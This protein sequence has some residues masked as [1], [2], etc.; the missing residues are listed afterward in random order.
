MNCFIPR[1]D[2]LGSDVATNLGVGLDNRNEYGRISYSGDSI[3]PD[4][5]TDL[6]NRRQKAYRV[7]LLE[8]CLDV[9]EGL[10]R[11]D[12]KHSLR[13]IS[14]MV[15]LSASTTH[16]I[17]QGLK[18]RGYVKQ[19]PKTL[20]YELSLKFFEIGNVIVRSLDLRE[21][22]APFLSELANKTGMSSQLL[23]IDQD[24]ALCIERI[25]GGHYIR[26]LFLQLGGRMPLHVGASPRVLLAGLPEKEVDR[27]I[28]SKGLPAWTK[29]S[30]TDPI[31]LKENLKEIREQGYALSFEDAT[32]HVAA[33]GCPVK[34]GKGEV[35]AAIS[36]AGI[37]PQFTGDKLPHLIREVRN[38]A[39]RISSHTGSRPAR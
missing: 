24:E 7:R 8:R 21:E 18:S 33:I 22:A 36:I 35:I 25:D 20:K 23:I 11:G 2:R 34:N 16:R 29:K 5:T 26:V 31:V 9:V 3:P 12:Q 37:R 32:E 10:A 30:I 15:A 17:L 39:D 27:I 28:R 19:D 13:E 6:G 4:R 1:E 14:R 38:A